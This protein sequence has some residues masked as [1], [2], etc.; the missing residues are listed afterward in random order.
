MML[1]MKG[2]LNTENKQLFL[3]T[4]TLHLFAISG[5]HVGIVALS[6]AGILNLLR[7]PAKV[8]VVVGLALVYAYVEITGA[9]PSAVRAFAMT[10][11][12][13]AGH[14]I[15]R[16]MPPFQ[17]LTAS[18]V[19]VLLLQPSQLFSPGFQLSYSV[20]SGILLWGMP[21]HRAARDRLYAAQPWKIRFQSEGEKRFFKVVEII[22]GA[23]IISLAAFLA[24]APLSILYFGIFPPPA[25]LLNLILVP[26]ATLVIFSGMLSLIFGL[27]GVEVLSV[28]F[29]HGPLTLILLTEKMLESLVDLPGFFFEMRWIHEPLGFL[30]LFIYLGSL[31]CGHSLRL[32]KPKLLA[33]PAASLA[34]ML[35][36][37]AL[38]LQL[39]SPAS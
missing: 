15:A 37:N 22:L 18:A 5:L 30:T 4:G 39:L 24:S 25:I 17:A 13:W 2:E 19:I 33:I 31:L 8:S 11:F 14:S 32:S 7:V 12:F 35:C 21:L 36:I 29:N 6:L 1:G 28:F 9:N 26:A 27:A 10:A 23:L 3:K 16:Q 38:S 34:I 20:V